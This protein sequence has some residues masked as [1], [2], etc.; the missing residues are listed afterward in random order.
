MPPV[1]FFLQLLEKGLSIPGI[2]SFQQSLVGVAHLGFANEIQTI[3]VA[4]SRPNMG[5]VRR[6]HHQGP[7]GLHHLSKHLNRHG[8]GL[9]ARRISAPLNKGA[10]MPA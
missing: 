1:T 7:A 3:G 5:Q 6:S 9:V 8:K 4:K 10:K 2:D